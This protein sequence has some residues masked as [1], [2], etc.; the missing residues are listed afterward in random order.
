MQIIPAIDIM[1]GQCVR[2]THGEFDTRTVYHKDPLDAALQF[3]EKGVE[4]LHLVDLDGARAGKVIN[5]EVLERLVQHTSLQIDFGGGVKSASD[6]SRVLDTG[7]SWV[8]I[9]SMAIKSPALVAE[10]MKEFGA[11]KFLLGADV[12]D[13][14][15]TIS[16]W[17]ESTDRDILSFIGEYLSMGVRQI[18][19]TDVNKDGALSGPATALY[20]KILEHYPD[21]FLIASGGVSSYEDLQKLQTIGC[22][23]VI[24]G[25]ALYEG[26]IDI[27]KIFQKPNS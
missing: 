14:K 12:R 16:G 21:I 2:L 23:G 17:Q 25:K 4:R 5:W 3:Q 19:C 13:E 1:D 24:I 22:K 26:R 11:E 9:G 6:V 8:T 18:F 7:A 27:A 15:I 10:W 20:E